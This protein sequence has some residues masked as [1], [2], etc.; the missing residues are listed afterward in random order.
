MYHKGAFGL[1]GSML[2][3][4]LVHATTS[5]Y[6]QMESQSLTSLLSALRKALITDKDESTVDYLIVC[7]KEADIKHS[8]RS[9]NVQEQM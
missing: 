7:Y 5:E 3:A 8:K 9:P 1:L 6:P 2:L 4:L